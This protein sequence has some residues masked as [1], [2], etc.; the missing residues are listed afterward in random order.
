MRSKS[1]RASTTLDDFDY[2]GFSA[3][4][5]DRVEELYFASNFKSGKDSTFLSK[6][7]NLVRSI[8]PAN[9]ASLLDFVTA[10][11]SNDKDALRLSKS[12]CRFSLFQ[13]LQLF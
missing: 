6:A 2:S 1:M 13:I 11:V 9:T 7:Y 5:D 10:M 4:L 3:K 12:T 8:A